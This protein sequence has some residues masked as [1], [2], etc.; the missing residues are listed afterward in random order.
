M[1]LNS[2]FAYSSDEYRYI[3]FIT[4]NII[5]YNTNKKFSQHI[6]SKE[7]IITVNH[8]NRGS[9]NLSAL[10]GVFSSEVKTQKHIGVGN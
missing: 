2:S 1:E 7:C 9:Q 4:A 8:T 3:F 5:K 10:E 6:S